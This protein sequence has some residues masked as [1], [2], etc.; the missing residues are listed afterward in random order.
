MTD[1]LHQNLIDGE[2]VGGD[3]V[4][5]NINPSN[6]NDVV[7][8]YAAGGDGRSHARD[9]RRQGRL[10]GLVARASLEVALR[11][12]RQGRR[13]RSWR[14]RKSSARLLSREEGK[15]LAEGIGEVD[16]RRRR[17]SSFSPARRCA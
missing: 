9:R 11:R 1:D 16:A 5:A 12:A 15:T 3:G 2:W 17:S 8:D 10:P 13:T 14:A 6:T 7:G 4:G